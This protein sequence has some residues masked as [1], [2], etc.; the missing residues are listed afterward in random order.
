MRCRMTEGA[1]IGSDGGTGEEGCSEKR[2]EETEGGW[3]PGAE[4][5]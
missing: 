5:V 4:V 3:G 2:E 1:L